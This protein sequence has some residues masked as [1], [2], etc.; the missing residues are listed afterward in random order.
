VDESSA[1]TIE[2]RRLGDAAV[3]T[4]IDVQQREIASHYGGEGGSGAPPREDEML[5]PA[6]AFLLALEDGRPVGCGGVCRLAPG[7]AE[8][9]RMYVAP[10]ARGRGL[11]RQLLRALEREAAGLGY[12][13]IRLETG[14][15]QREAIGLYESAGY[16]PAPCWGPYV[17]DPRS[18]CYEKALPAG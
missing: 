15:R 5:P 1:V 2:R 4:L 12:T 16:R 10:E 13:T 8:I 3:Q 7:V 17:T 14:D 18:R 9:R 11:G 6:G